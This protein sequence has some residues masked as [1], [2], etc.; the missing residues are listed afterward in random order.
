[1]PEKRGRKTN[2]HMP[3]LNHSGKIRL[4]FNAVQP[5]VASEPELCG[6]GI[7]PWE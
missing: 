6:R 5:Q 4:C 2:P 3:L 7:H 1:M